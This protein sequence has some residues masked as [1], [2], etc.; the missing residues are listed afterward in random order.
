MFMGNSRLERRTA[1]ACQWNISAAVD[2]Q[3]RRRARP[4]Q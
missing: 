1:K 2:L 3:P 4:R